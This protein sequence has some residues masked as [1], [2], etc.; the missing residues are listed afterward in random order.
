MINIKDALKDFNLLI[1]CCIKDNNVITINTE[2][3][4]VVMLTEDNYNNLIESLSLYTNTKIFKSICE[5]VNTCIEN[6]EKVNWK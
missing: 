2:D 1:D 5:G 6:C 3:G 4:N